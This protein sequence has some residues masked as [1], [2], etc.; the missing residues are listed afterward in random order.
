MSS[1]CR[2]QLR[3]SYAAR[4]IDCQSAAPV[5]EMPIDDPGWPFGPGYSESKWVAERV[6]QNITQRR[7]VHTVVMRLGQVAG[8]RTGHWNEREWFPSLVKSAMFQKC[9]PEHDG[10]SSAHCT[11]IRV[12]R[13]DCSPTNPQK[14]AWVPAYE[15]ARAFAEMRRSPEPIVHLVHPRPVLWRT[16]LA[17]IAQELN[18]PLVPYARWLSALGGSVERG[19]AEE[20]EAMRLNPALRLLSFYEAQGETTEGT[21]DREAMGLVFIATDKAVRVSKSLARLPQLDGERAMMW[22]A[23]WRKSG[24]VSC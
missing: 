19:S 12:H 2:A 6:L 9:L 15:A 1:H 22:L 7:G 5:P 23:A 20:V 17:P 24:F 13:A 16:L 3:Y 18:V 21:P 11:V 14:V 10:V 8:D 4:H